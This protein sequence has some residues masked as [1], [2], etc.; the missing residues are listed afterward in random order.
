MKFATKKGLFAVF[1]ALFPISIL[2]LSYDAVLSLVTL[3]VS[4]IGMQ[5]MDTARKGRARGRRQLLADFF[6]GTEAK[7]RKKTPSWRVKWLVA[8]LSLCVVGLLFM[9]TLPIVAFILIFAFIVNLSVM[10]FVSYVEEQ[11]EDA[12]NDAVSR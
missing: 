7:E 8:S 5:I 10:L 4:I 11:P 3:V 1:V 12:Q 9:N 2:L 6:K